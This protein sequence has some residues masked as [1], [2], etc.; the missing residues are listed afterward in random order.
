MWMTMLN[1]DIQCV[2]KIEYVVDREGR[3]GEGEDGKGY[4]E[5]GK[6]RY[7]RT[8]VEVQ[9]LAATTTERDRGVDRS[10]HKTPKEQTNGTV[11]R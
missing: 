6:E 8:Q 1:E 2:G 3:E 4:T 5:E 11:G 7:E 10:L 9:A